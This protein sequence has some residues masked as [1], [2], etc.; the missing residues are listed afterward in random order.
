MSQKRKLVSF[1]FKVAES[2]P[3]KL[4]SGEKKK[5]RVAAL[6]TIPRE[7]FPA[8]LII[9]LSFSYLFNFSFPDSFLL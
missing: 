6:L 3:G 1:Y 2:Y 5:K 7:M 4:A 9:S 8:S